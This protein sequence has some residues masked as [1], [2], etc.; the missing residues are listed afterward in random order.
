MDISQTVSPRMRYRGQVLNQVYRVW[1]FR[2]L[3]PVLAVEIIA[4]AGLIY[5]LARSVFV[6]HV[7]ENAIKVSSGNPIQIVS[8]FVSAFNHTSIVTKGVMLG[9]AVVVALLLRSITQGILRLIL[10]RQNYFGR[11]EAKKTQ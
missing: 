9:L 5:G 6:A 2:K 10:V 3:M 1:L 7:L 11:I 4:V 8:F